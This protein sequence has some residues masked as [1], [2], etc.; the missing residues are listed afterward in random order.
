MHTS[1]QASQ[2]FIDMISSISLTKVVSEEVAITWIGFIAENS[3]SL[4]D[5][6]RIS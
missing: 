1:V 4:I 6:N 3:L 2:K 5:E